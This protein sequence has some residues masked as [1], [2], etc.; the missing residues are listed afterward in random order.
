MYANNA[1]YDTLVCYVLIACYAVC[2]IHWISS[3]D[4]M[5]V[6]DEL[7]HLRLRLPERLRPRV[8]P[9]FRPLDRDRERF[10]PPTAGILFVCGILT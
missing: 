7:A 3:V 9:P 4:Q 2:V 1:N 8:L 6:V 10:L 5:H